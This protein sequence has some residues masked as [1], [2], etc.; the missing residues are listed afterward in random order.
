MNPLNSNQRTLPRPIGLFLAIA[1]LSGGCVERTLL[2]ETRPP[3]AIVFLDDEL[4]R[5]DEGKP[6]LTPTKVSF[7]HYGTREVVVRREDHLSANRRVEL[8]PPV[9]QIFPLDLFTDLLIPYTFQDLHRV[10]I[11]L[12]PA[13][14]PTETASGA[15]LQRAR[16]YREQLEEPAEVD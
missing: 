2:I 5:D 7:H 8:A 14:T 12:E 10:E 11:E 1:L 6:L 16:E 4:L 9:Y 15:L 3:G 13:P